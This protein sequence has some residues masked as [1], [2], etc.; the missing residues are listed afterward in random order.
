MEVF[1]YIFQ[2]AILFLSI[3]IHEI[4]HGSMALALGDSTAKDMGR[5]T[6]NPIKHFDLWGTFLVPLISLLYGGFIIGW[7]KPVPFNPY[8]LKNPKRD[9]GL[10]GLAGPASNLVVACFFGG[11][12][13]LLPYLGIDFSNVIIYIFHFIV[14]VNLM[15][16]VFNLI[17]IPPLDGSRILYAILPRSAEKFI[18][19]VER[20]GIFFLLIIIFFGAPYLGFVIN[21]LVK[22]ISGQ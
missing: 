8:N 21:F 11:L 6:F 7:A 5:L 22:I 3:I 4:S 15:L 1:I 13:R 10:I 14:Y 16:M 20:Y 18:F 12:I 19:S 17:P 9:T 2:F